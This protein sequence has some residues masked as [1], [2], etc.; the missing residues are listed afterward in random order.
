M[1]RYLQRTKAYK[2]VY[3]NVDNL[4]LFGYTDSDFVG[5]LDDRR[6]ISGYIFFLAGGVVSWRSAKQKTLAT[7]TMQAEYVAC[8]EAIEQGMLL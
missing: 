8:F 6:S 7:S 3:R 1:V 5:C 4:E 2:L